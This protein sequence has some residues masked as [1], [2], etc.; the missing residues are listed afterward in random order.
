MED[1]DAVAA[2]I[3][4]TVGV[5][6]IAPLTLGKQLPASARQPPGST[7]SAHRGRSR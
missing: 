1:R 7:V 5:T 6:K 2:A 3:I 4:K